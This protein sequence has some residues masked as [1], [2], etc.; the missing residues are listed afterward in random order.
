M[1]RIISIITLFLIFTLLSCDAPAG[2]E[3]DKPVSGPGCLAPV[4]II[5][6]DS[7]YPATDIYIHDTPDYRSLTPVAAN[8]D[9]DDATLP[10]ASPTIINGYKKYITYVRDDPIIGPIG[11]TTESPIEFKE[12]FKYRLYLLNEDFFLETTG[13]QYSRRSEIIEFDTLDTSE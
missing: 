6:N 9:S 7:D 8:L 3:S 11:I 4:L 2:D 12:C 5:E 1:K 13:S 10:I